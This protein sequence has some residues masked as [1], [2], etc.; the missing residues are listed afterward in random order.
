MF[1]FDIIGKY[2]PFLEHLRRHFFLLKD[3]KILGAQ[4]LKVQSRKSTTPTLEHSKF[5]VGIGSSHVQ[6]S[7]IAGNIESMLNFKNY[8]PRDKPLVSTNQTPAYQC[9]T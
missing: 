8:L 4:E 5:G 2:W 6:P 1:L 3:E 7:E 9:A